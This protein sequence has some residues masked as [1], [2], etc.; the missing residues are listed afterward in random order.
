MRKQYNGR[1]HRDLIKQARSFTENWGSFPQLFPAFYSR[2]PSRSV[3]KDD[4]MIVLILRSNGI[5]IVGILAFSNKYFVVSLIPSLSRVDS[6]A[7]TTKTE[8]PA[9]VKL[10]TDICY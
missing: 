4:K 2:W 6:P 8:T 10:P 1:I 7:R 5:A 3:R 9:Y